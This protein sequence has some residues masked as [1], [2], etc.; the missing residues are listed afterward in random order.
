[1]SKRKSIVSAFGDFRNDPE[2]DTPKAEDKKDD[3]TPKA[4]NRVA[5]GI[6][7]ATQRTMTQI[8]E[9]RDR[10][11]EQVADDSRVIMLDPG[12]VDPSPFRDRLPDDDDNEFAEFKQSLDLQGQ[13]VPI[14]VRRHPDDEHRYQ[15]VYGHRR[16]RAFKE[17]GK[18]IEAIVADYSDR[19]LVIAQGIENA[20]RQDLSWIERALFAHEMQDAGIKPKDIKAALSVD[21]TELSKFRTVL[22]ALP[23]KIIEAIGRAPSIGRPR[24]LDLAGLAKSKADITRLEK[25]LA[26]AKVSNAPSDQRFLE[27]LSSLA[28]PAAQP[29]SD[30]SQM[31]MELDDVGSM[32]VSEKA[33]KINL[34]KEHRDGFRRFLEI[35]MKGLVE[36]Y[37][38]GLKDQ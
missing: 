16:W 12:I 32:T 6:V 2:A 13:I 7:G 17:L 24:W 29:K 22:R 9:E 38:A 35:E 27:A 36:R 37:K 8:R 33:I 26:A 31:S 11:L 19:E 3:T 34:V 10:L 18:D 20:S 14:T 28:E 1:M 25:T 15:V 5:A 21:D 23:P 30:P 4:S